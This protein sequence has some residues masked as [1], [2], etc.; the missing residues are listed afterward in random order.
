M[1]ILLAHNYY[2]SGS[3]SGEDAV[4]ANE[5]LLLEQAGHEVIAFERSNDAIGSGLTSRLTAAVAASWSQS[6]HRELTRL[7]AKHRPQVAHFHNTFPLL[8][9]STYA[10]CRQADVPVVQTLHN[11]RLICPGALLMRDGKPCEQCI[12]QSPW[13]AVRHACYR[14]SRTATTVVATMLSVHRLRKTYIDDVDC[15]IAL[16]DFARQRFIR[17]GLPATKIVVRPNCLMDMPA[18]GHGAGGYALYVGRL[19]SEKG[20][21][22]LVE[23]WRGLD[24]PLKIVG[25]GILR[26]ELEA[27]ASQST[28]RIEFLGFRKRDEVLA[29]MRDAAFVIIPSECY[30]GFPVTVLEALATGTPLIVSALGALDEIVIAPRHGLKFQA[31]DRDSLRS[32]VTALLAQPELQQAM[33]RDNR[34]LFESHYCADRGLESLIGIYERARRAAET[35]LRPALAGA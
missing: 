3:P 19:S 27:R 35:S 31:G 8:S 10:A 7:I 12:G 21:R 20:V 18:V 23:A 32:S 34:A 29:L 2:Q 5:R 24:C 4:F 22:T 11:Y 25:D 13:P 6:S 16:T 30:E 17:G 14:N 26:A 1:R 9:P 33:R 28:S 15:Y